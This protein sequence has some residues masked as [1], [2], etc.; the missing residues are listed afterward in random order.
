[1]GAK[2]I[3][4]AYGKAV[5]ATAFGQDF[6]PSPP[7]VPF[8]PNA[9][10]LKIDGTIGR[11]IAVE[12]ESRASKQVRGAIIDIICHPFPRKLLVLIRKY[13]N[14]FTENQCREILKRFAP[15]A[16]SI[17]LTLAG[18]GTDIKMDE[19]VETVKAAVYLLRK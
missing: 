4:D 13:G 14:D 12:I 3:H 2:Q 5:L 11:D 6:N 7:P 8:G 19:D 1:M 17:V 18:S 9:G 15:A 16:N 10:T